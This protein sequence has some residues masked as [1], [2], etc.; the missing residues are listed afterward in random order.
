MP[1]QKRAPLLEF[2]DAFIVKG[3]LQVVDWE[4]Q[5]HQFGQ[6]NAKPVVVRLPDPSI[7]AQLL[8]HPRLG[9]G[10]AWMEGR[11]E[12]LQGTLF[13][14]LTVLARNRGSLRKHSKSAMAL[15]M[16]RL[17]MRSLATYNPP[18]RAQKNAAHYELSQDFFRLFLDRELQYSCGYYQS[19]KDDLETA[20]QQKMHYLAQKLL[21]NEP[22][23]RV[24]DVGCGW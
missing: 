21:L 16:G 20:Q 17:W 22:G 19:P 15:H 18:A 14:F 4:G 10:E 8:R 9:M 6:Q 3:H 12:L 13:D 2:L 7:Q 5:E 23:L 11:I 24:L 1:K